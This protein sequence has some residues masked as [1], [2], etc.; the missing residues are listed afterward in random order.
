M[1]EYEFEPIRGLPKPLPAG[2][3]LLWQGAPCWWSLARRTFHLN[4]VAIYFGVLMSWRT[5]SALGDGQSPLNAFLHGLWLLVPALTAIGLLAL[6]AWLYS[7]TTVFTLTSQRVIMRFG[8]AL[9]MTVNV[10]FRIIDRAGLKRYRDGTGDLPLSTGSERTSYLVMWPFVRP[11]RISR[12][13]PMLRAVPAA[14]RVAEILAGA[15]AAAADKPVQ[16][17]P[18]TEGSAA[19]RATASRPP[20]TAVA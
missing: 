16:W 7:R 17:P 15:L 20:K 8:I 2:E 12:P 13:Q 1:N 18:R 19:A 14:D 4:K 6:F 5:A 11:W 3:R 10:P 9:S